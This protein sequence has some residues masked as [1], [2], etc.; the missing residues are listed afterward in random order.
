[1]YF[2]TLSICIK[3]LIE[4]KLRHICNGCNSGIALVD[5]VVDY[6]CSCSRT[7]CRDNKILQK[8]HVFDSFGKNEV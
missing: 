2:K 6:G 3:F 7:W 5:I 4:G 8:I 1:M